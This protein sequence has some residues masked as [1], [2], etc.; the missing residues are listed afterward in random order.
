MVGLPSF[1]QP[2]ISPSDQVYQFVRSLSIGEGSLAQPSQPCWPRSI[3]MFNSP[4]LVV[5]LDSTTEYVLAVSQS[6]SL[7][8]TPPAAVGSLPFTRTRTWKASQCLC[9]YS[10]RF[11]STIAESSSLDRGLSKSRQLHQRHQLSCISRKQSLRRLFTARLPWSNHWHTSLHKEGKRYALHNHASIQFQ[12]SKSEFICILI[13]P[14]KHILY[15][16][17]RTWQASQW[18][19]MGKCPPL[20]S[21]PVS[22]RLSQVP[23]PTS[24]LPSNRAALFIQGSL[25]QG[26]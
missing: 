15:C 11:E 10:K 14:T 2:S 24:T 4:G 16:H 17:R 3:Y 18:H 20:Q 19:G 12:S 7:P 22:S 26:I 9:L 25:E 5:T 13:G 8:P 21:I 23:P 1:R 6:F